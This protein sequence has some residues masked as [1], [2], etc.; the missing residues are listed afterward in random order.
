MGKAPTFSGSENVEGF[1]RSWEKWAAGRQVAEHLRYPALEG[2]LRREAKD[3]SYNLQYAGEP[4]YEELKAALLDN[5]GESALRH[6]HE[7]ENLKRESRS[8]AEYN[9]EF[10][11]LR[12]KCQRYLPTAYQEVQAYTKGLWPADL[13]LAIST[14]RPANLQRAMELATHLEPQIRAKTQ[15]VRDTREPKCYSCG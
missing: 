10:L 11:Q 13:R 9:K 3:F 12:N 2:A 8:I 14:N 4:T 6:Y 5:Y 15:S 7:L 1:L